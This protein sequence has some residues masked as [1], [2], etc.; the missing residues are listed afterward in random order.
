MQQQTRTSCTGEETRVRRRRSTQ[1]L[2]RRRALRNLWLRVQ[3]RIRRC[4]DLRLRTLAE[5]VWQILA[6]CSLPQSSVS[7]NFARPRL[8]LTPREFS[9]FLAASL[10]SSSTPHPPPPTH[11]LPPSSSVVGGSLPHQSLLPVTQSRFA[12]VLVSFP[13]DSCVSS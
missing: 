12:F 3:R 9:S 8:P 1:Q 2:R 5:R 11:L 7:S 4:R 13:W 6:Q 10:V